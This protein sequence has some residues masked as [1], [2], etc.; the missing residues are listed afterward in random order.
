M[1][2]CNKNDQIHKI[3]WAN[4]IKDEYPDEGNFQG[5]ESFAGHGG[6]LS[7]KRVCTPAFFIL[8]HLSCDTIIESL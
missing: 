8:P 1:N 3:S 4:A 5:M 6:R 2:Y 7:E